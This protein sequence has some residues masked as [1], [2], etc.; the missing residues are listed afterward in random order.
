MNKEFLGSR[1]V[2]AGDVIGKIGSTGNSSGAHLHFEFYKT[3]KMNSDNKSMKKGLR[4]EP[5]NYF[6]I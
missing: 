4:L 1:R 3:A 2:N 5:N 6:D